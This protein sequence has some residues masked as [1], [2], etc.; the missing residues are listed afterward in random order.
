MRFKSEVKEGM[1]DLGFRVPE[2]ARHFIFSETSSPNLR[3]SQP[4]IRRLSV[5]I[6]DSKAE[7]T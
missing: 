3:P 7:E 5:L 1:E 4:F 6:F 2:G